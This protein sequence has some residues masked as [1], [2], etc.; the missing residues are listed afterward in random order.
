MFTGHEFA[1]GAEVILKTLKK[2]QAKA[3]FFLTGDFYRNPAFRKTIKQLKKAGHY[4]GAHSD[5]HVLYA[6]WVKRDSLLVTHTQFIKDLQDNYTE[7]ARFGIKKE[8]APFYLPPYEWYNQQ[9]SDWTK[10]QGL[11]LINYTPGTLSHADY[12]YPS[13]GKQYRTSEVIYHSILEYEHKDKNGL[14]G[15]L[16]LL[17][18]GTEPARPDKFHHKLD[19][20]M[21]ELKAKGYQFVSLPNLLSE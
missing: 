7:M 12:T 18:I 1:D 13:L 6:D 16:L 15:F 14:N 19:Q 20:L 9:I 5:K 21:L 2:H 3:A 10:A 17:H 11:Q 8:Q 4:L